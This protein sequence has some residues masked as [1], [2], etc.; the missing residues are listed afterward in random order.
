MPTSTTLLTRDRNQ[1]LL[2]DPQHPKSSGIY[3]KIPAS[4]L[5]QSLANR[6]S[7]RLE[8]ALINVATADLHT[9]PA[10]SVHSVVDEV[11][12]P[13]E[14]AV[15]LAEDLWGARPEPNVSVN[16]PIS[17]NEDVKAY[18]DLICRMAA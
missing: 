8:A 7:L 18:G 6:H 1:P 5:H 17:P 16:L 11:D 3:Q 4:P 14:E 15:E 13:D 10:S 2:Q 12:N 9:H